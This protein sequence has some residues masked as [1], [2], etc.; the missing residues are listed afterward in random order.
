MSINLQNIN[1]IRKAISE[2]DSSH[3][4]DWIGEFYADL[5]NNWSSDAPSIDSVRTKI[6][7]YKL[8]ELRLKRNE[9]LSETDW[10]GGTDVP[11]TLKTTWNTYR[12]S[13]RDITNTYTSLDDVVWPTKP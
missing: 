13:L 9:L 8:D 7:E 5:E 3:N 6:S 2:L 10:V 4:Q 12:Q 1:L 11:N